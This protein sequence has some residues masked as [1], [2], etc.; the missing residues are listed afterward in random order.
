M[1]TNRP[2]LAATVVLSFVLLAGCTELPGKADHNLGSNLS[3][4]GSFQQLGESIQQEVGKAAATVEQA[5]EKTAVKVSDS[6]TADWT[7]TELS[8]SQ[9]INSASTLTMVNPVGKI[10]VRPVTGEQLTV[11]AT[12]RLEKDS[13]HEADHQIIMDNAEVSIQLS[14]DRVNVSTHSKENPGQDLWSWAQDELDDSDFTI[15]YAIGVPEGIDTFEI[16]NNVGEIRLQDLKG[17]YH[18]TSNVGAIHISGAEVTGSSTVEA[19]TG[20]IRLDLA[21][22]AE[23]SSLKAKTDVG[24]LTAILP[25]SMGCDLETSSELGAITGADS[26]TSKLNGG[27]PLLSLSSKIGSITVHQ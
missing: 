25:E 6:I 7:S 24:S 17:V 16:T 8:A 13:A 18:V 4:E 15:D 12:V 2:L 23:G 20:S 10:E 22:M 19:N 27:G 3:G 1:R 26:G 21:S 5:V 9:A 14:G 11:T